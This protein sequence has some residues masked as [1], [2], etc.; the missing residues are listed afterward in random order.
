MSKTP[1]GIMRLLAAKPATLLIVLLLMIFIAYANTLTSPPVLDD[2]LTFLENSKVHLRDF[3]FASIKQLTATEFGIA[4]FI[5][6]LTFA[7]NNKLAFGNLPY[8]H[9]TNISIH[10]LAVT[11]L[12]FFLQGLFARTTLRDQR[13]FLPSTLLTIG[14]CGLW[15]LSPVQTNAVTYLVQRMTSLMALFY[16]LAMTFYLYGR[17]AGPGAIRYLHLVLCAGSAGL[18]FMSKENSATLPLALLLL[19]CTIINPGSATRFLAG[20]K[21][22]H[23]LCLGLILLIALPV[24][25][26]IV[27]EMINNYEGRPFTCAERLLT[28]SR[29]VVWYMS[30]LALPL[31]SRMNLDH[32]F[33]ISRSLLAPPTTLLSIILLCLIVATTFK[34]RHKSPLLTFGVFFFFL[35]LIIESTVVPLELVFEHR[36]YLPSVGFFLA[37]AGGIDLLLT[38]FHKKSGAECRDYQPFWVGLVIILSISSVLTTFRNNDWQD[39]S[40]LYADSLSKSPGKP[41]AYANYGMALGREGFCD[42]AI[43]ILEKGISLGTRNNEQY[44]A[45]AN[46]LVNCLALTAGPSQAAARAEELYKNLPADANLNALPDFLFNLGNNYWASG[47]YPSALKA[48]QKALRAESPADNRYIL[49]ALAALVNEVYKTKG[50]A[51]LIGMADLRDRSTAVTYA[52]A[53]ISLEIRDYETAEEFLAKVDT[54]SVNQEQGPLL[55]LKNRLTDERLRNRLVA[56][57]TDISRDNFFNS[58]RKNR[59][60]LTL[61]RL[62]TNHYPPLYFLADWMLT[63]LRAQNPC[64]PFVEWYIINLR[65]TRKSSTFDLDSLKKTIAANPNFAPLLEI[66]ANYLL[67]LSRKEEA[68]ASGERLL[69]IYPGSPNWRYW[70]ITLKELRKSS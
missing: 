36:L 38:S 63:R 10:L 35:N 41:R 48:Y 59:M 61:S 17:T 7:I 33:L 44:L 42:K 18:A 67:A 60:M 6:M 16:L 49:T 11:T 50:D 45:S 47:N 37:L 2:I 8:Y 69:K 22:R 21:T 4:R 5:P 23:W 14:V 9:L 28:E 12:Y 13:W 62:I 25:L 70:Q 54:N 53:E 57:A 1:S 56:E 43:P 58:S 31:P 15:G 30:L 27:G 68:L 29:V 3:S 39:P 34:Y 52:I 20:L 32:D 40:T 26:K 46:N 19:E 66:E 64:N 65:S 51:S 24:P 55:K